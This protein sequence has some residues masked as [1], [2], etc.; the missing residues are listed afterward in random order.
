MY[1]HEYRYLWRPEEVIKCPEAAV[2]SCL[3]WKLG[4][5]FGSSGSLIT[6]INISPALLR[7]GSH[8]VIPT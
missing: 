3:K 5:A 4:T 2:T 8:Y 6:P 7:Q 1:A